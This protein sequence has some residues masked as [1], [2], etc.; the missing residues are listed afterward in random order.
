MRTDC[1][2]AIFWSIIHTANGQFNKS[3]ATLSMPL[4]TPALVIILKT[5]LFPLIYHNGVMNGKRTQSNVQAIHILKHKIIKPS[6]H[7]LKSRPTPFAVRWCNGF[8]HKQVEIELAD[9]TYVGT[10]CWH[11]KLHTFVA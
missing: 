9:V 5:F 6:M 10:T 11:S 8:L 3:S 7:Q 4:N 1:I 2:C